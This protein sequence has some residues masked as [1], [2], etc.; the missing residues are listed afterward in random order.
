MPLPEWAFWLTLGVMVVG[1]VGTLV[2]VLPGVEL[3]WLAAL[4]YAIAER[5]ATIDPLTFAA[6]TAL[7]AIGITANIWASHLGSRL[8][9][10]SWQAL[11]AGLGLG[12]EDVSSHK[13]TK[14]QRK[15]KLYLCVFVPLCEIFLNNDAP[16]GD[17]EE[18]IRQPQRVQ[19]LL[20]T[21][22]S[23]LAG[24][25][26]HRQHALTRTGLLQL[27]VQNQRAQ[28]VGTAPALSGERLGR[29]QF[30]YPPPDF[31]RRNHCLHRHR[32][33]GR[34]HLRG[35]GRS[36]RW[37]LFYAPDRQSFGEGKGQGL[38]DALWLHR[39][40]QPEV[41]PLR[42][43]CEPQREGQGNLKAGVRGEA[44]A[45]GQGQARPPDGSFPH[46]HLLQVGDVAQGAIYGIGNAPA[47]SRHG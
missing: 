18:A 42:L 36:T 27:E 2:P 8:G 13:D 35:E 39:L 6:L 7:A 28:V 23:A 1:L 33:P 20:R 40:L 4:V 47:G 29:Q 16:S 21:A 15:Y 32:V 5:F 30:L 26:E 11:L 37:N 10:A 45:V 19:H 3:I 12:A 9:G 41:Q 34:H 14:A 24:R 38:D 31:I 43:R 25:K 17:P 46:P 44:A 22:R